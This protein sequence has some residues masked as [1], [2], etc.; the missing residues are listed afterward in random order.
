MKRSFSQNRFA[1]AR[2]IFG[3]LI[4]L[5]LAPATQGA[6]I[7]DGGS[8]GPGDDY[9]STATNWV[10]D[11]VPTFPAALTFGGSTRLNPPT[12]LPP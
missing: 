8:I 1:V 3:F 9:W 7:W 5:L 12:T 2:L 6:D 11:I 4:S 10:D